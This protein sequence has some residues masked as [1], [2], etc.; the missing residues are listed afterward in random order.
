ME[1]GA[2]TPRSTFR[3]S[4]KHILVPESRD[5]DATVIG[6]SQRHT[7][8]TSWGPMAAPAHSGAVETQKCEVTRVGGRLPTE[9]SRRGLA[10]SVWDGRSPNTAVGSQ[11]AR[12]RGQPRTGMERWPPRQ[13]WEGRGGRGARN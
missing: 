9:Q 2:G 13:V 4:Q 1:G 11:A 10:V 6:A 7:P 12:G 3:I 5:H 8:F